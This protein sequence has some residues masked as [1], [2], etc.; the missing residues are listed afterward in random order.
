MSSAAILII[1]NEILSGGTQ[2][3]NS[4][5]MA[6]QLTRHGIDV[7][8]IVTVPDRRSAIAEW[9]RRLH[10]EHT[11]LFTS[12]GI[13]PTPDDMTREA[14][15]DALGLAL[16]PHAQA[17]AL[18]RATM[19]GKMT[20]ID[21][22]MAELPAGLRLVHGPGCRAPAFQVENIFILPGVPS[23]LRLMFASALSVLPQAPYAS[24]ILRCELSEGQI[25]GTMVELEALFPD[26]RIGSYPH[27]DEGRYDLELK[28][29]T[30]RPGIIDEAGAWLAA[31]LE[32][33]AK[34][35]AP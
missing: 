26:V 31:R 20:D 29:E 16:E 30:K 24:R 19:G 35:A 34:D 4:S 14:V 2:D 7:E 32:S 27:W 3:V 6:G 17:E 8:L 21:R 18:L 10:K 15:A 1:G 9:V 22:K 33:L 11:F 13:G 5:W 23:L 12:G 28:L 25:A